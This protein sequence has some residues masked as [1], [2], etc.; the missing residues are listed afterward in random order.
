MASSARLA[1]WARSG[2][3]CA[4]KALLWSFALCALFMRETGFC[5]LPPRA[6]GK[7]M[8]TARRFFG[9]GS[10]SEQFVV[11]NV[12]KLV[13]ELPNDFSALEWQPLDARGT[14]YFNAMDPNCKNYYAAAKLDS[15]PTT[16]QDEWKSRG[17]RD[18]GCSSTN[19]VHRACGCIRC[20]S[21]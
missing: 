15:W 16:R 12:F 21:L 19:H 17:G 11:G 8:A 4:V 3:P 2:R 7:D 20:S 5:G 10:D 18:F 14:R 1:G 9:G 13:K 6:R